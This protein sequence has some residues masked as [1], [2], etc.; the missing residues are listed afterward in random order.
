M[1]LGMALIF[2]KDMDRMTAFYRDAIG[3]EFLSGESSDGWAVFNGGGAR[4]ALHAIP[5]EIAKGIDIS[6]PPKAR[7]DTPIKLF[8]R[9]ANLQEARAHL[10]ANGAVMFEPAHGRCDGLDPEGNVFSI[11]T[12]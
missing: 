1:Q 12:E 5:L 2:A 6:V 8:F 10:L 3:L 4:L 11:V 7:G 9:S